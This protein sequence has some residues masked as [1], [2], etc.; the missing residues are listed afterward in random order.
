[1]TP[2]F[3]VA[4][5]AQRRMSTEGVN[6]TLPPVAQDETAAAEGE[7]SASPEPYRSLMLRKEELRRRQQVLLRRTD[8]VFY[9]QQMRRHFQRILDAVELTF[10]DTTRKK[11]VNMNLAKP[12]TVTELRHLSPAGVR[13]P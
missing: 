1:V 13:Q 12:L 3:S 8:V 6:T 7:R 2:H 9:R 11:K 5:A 4:P 10:S